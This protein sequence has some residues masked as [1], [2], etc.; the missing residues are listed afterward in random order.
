MN[1]GFTTTKSIL[2]AR[3]RREE[4]VESH[5]AQGDSNKIVQCCAETASQRNDVSHCFNWDS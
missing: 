3:W 1:H 5:Q 4:A 2:L